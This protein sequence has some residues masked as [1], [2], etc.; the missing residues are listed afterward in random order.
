MNTGAQCSGSTPH[1]AWTTTTPGGKGILQRGGKKRILDLM[2]ANGITYAATVNIAYPEDFIAR[3][4]EAKAI[5]GP[6]FVH[7]LTPCP[8][9]WR[10]DSR[11]TVEVA[12]WQH[13][14]GIF[15]LYEYRNGKYQFTKEIKNR[16]PVE[17]YLRPPGALQAPQPGAGRADPGDRIVSSEELKAKVGASRK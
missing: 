6:R 4:R 2:V 1:G 7:A 16:K 10:M 14:Q 9:G 15:P 8:S 17:E 11:R 5:R 3:V 13:G 12:P